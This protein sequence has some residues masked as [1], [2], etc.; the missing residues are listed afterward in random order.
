VFAEVRLPEK[1]GVRA[2]RFGVHPALLDAVLQAAAFVDLAPVPA[3]RMPFSFEGVVLHASGASEVRARVTRI[4]VD[5]VAV[6]VVDLSGAPVLSIRSLTLRPVQA[7]VVAPAAGGSMLTLDWSALPVV[8]E[9]SDLDLTVI[10][11][12]GD[13]AVVLSVHELTA[14]VL[15][16]L[17]VWLAR[18]E[19]RLVVFTRSGDLAG[20]AVWGLVRSAQAENPGRITLVESDVDLEE[21]VLAAA[22]AGEEPQLLFREGVFH[23]GRLNRVQPGGGELPSLG[24]G[25][26]LITG[27]TGGLGRELA[28][29]LVARHGVTDLLLVSRHG[30]SAEGAAEF[31]TELAAAGATTVIRAC[32]VTDRVALEQVL[33]GVRLSAVIHAAGIVDDALV[34]SLDA[35]RLDRVLGVKVDAAWHLHELTLD[36]G[37]AAFVVFSSL[38]GVLGSPGQGN[39]AAGN[40]FLD[41]LMRHR[42]DRGLPG[43]SMAWGPWVGQSGLTSTLSEGDLRRITESGT[44]A[45]SVEQGLGLFDQALAADQPVVAL[46]R[47]DLIVLRARPDL[48]ALWHGLTGGPQRPTAR[49]Q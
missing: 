36:A 27:G 20:A 8:E 1:E 6:E 38:A 32:D 47:L 11:A 5:S 16:E 35:A 29:H 42:R 43:V 9:R 30:A 7:G 41:A 26:V 28:R 22:A 10:R 40:V 24:E 48:P 37:L 13:S 17:Q 34:T 14:R 33:T 12:V 31:V 18:D 25:T 46:T 4:G 39:Y 3:G 23:A 45:L 19:G 2:A 21:S 44:P 15:G 49:Q